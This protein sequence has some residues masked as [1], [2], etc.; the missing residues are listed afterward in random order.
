MN[1]EESENEDEPVEP[2]SFSVAMEEMFEEYD[3]V[4]AALA[5]R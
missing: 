5:D 1:E 2:V 4:F 3:A